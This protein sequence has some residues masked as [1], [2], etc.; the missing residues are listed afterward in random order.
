[1][2][3]QIVS[4]ILDPK[5]IRED[6]LNA[7]FLSECRLLSITEKE[8]IKKQFILEVFNSGDDSRIK[9]YIQQHQRAII[10]LADLLFNYLQA[11][12][13]KNINRVTK[14]KAITELYE[15][16]YIYLEDLL[17]F[18]E[19]N[20]PK[21]FD[22]DLKIPDL[23]RWKIAAE[24]KNGLKL[25]KTSLQRI[26]V[27]DALIKVICH[28]FEDYQIP[29]KLISYRELFYL[30]ELQR[31][32]LLAAERKETDIINLLHYLNFNSIRFF[33]FY[34]LQLG[35][36]TKGIDSDTGLIE[37]FSLKMKIL[38][39]VPMKPGFAYR[40]QLPSIRDQI[41]T[42]ITEE[43]YFLEKRRQLNVPL[44]V[45]KSDEPV[46]T[47]KVQ[48]SLSVAHLSLGLKL[49]MDAGVI[50]NKNST[51]VMRMVAR[52]FRTEKRESISED[53]LRNK[54][55]NIESG[56]VEGMKDVIIGLLNL[57][58]GY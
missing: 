8:R 9:L 43:L 12:G 14:Q 21:H 41:G 18:I 32:I 53:S 31:E 42:W 44:N 39:Q 35:E 23:Y 56:T 45:L 52:N 19:K 33:N 20:F 1:M 29:E 11:N 2:L 36:L 17:Y 46:V 50:T 24:I 7:E 3:E 13:D 30:K 25:I 38:N 34:I 10:G 51:E 54:V 4:V 28:P 49:L 58:R 27:N 57:V 6:Q 37:Y 16:L 22:R 47:P 15:V 26:K 48:T 55:Y 5:K 40:P